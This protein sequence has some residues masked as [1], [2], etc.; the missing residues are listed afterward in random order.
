MS[1]EL[2]ELQQQVAQ[3]NT[4]TANEKTAYKLELPG[5][6]TPPNPTIDYLA[7]YQ[8]QRAEVDKLRAVI[9]AGRFQPTAPHPDANV[10]VKTF[11][12]ARAQIGA[13]RWHKLSDSEIL[14]ALG[15]NPNQDRGFISKLWA[16]GADPRLSAD[17]HKVNPRLYR[18]T[19]QAALALG[20]F[21]A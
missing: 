13:A 16:R 10:R 4:E 20:I 11:E 3:I 19:K 6:S 2:T 18:E 5:E 12:E 17:L 14:V 8:E 7:L 9:D 21:A 15:Q 1:T